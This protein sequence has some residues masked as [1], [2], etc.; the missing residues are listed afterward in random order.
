M[1]VKS[2]AE[3]HAIQY[4]L[5]YIIFKSF[6]SQAEFEEFIVFLLLDIFWV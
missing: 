4:M 6:K 1:H 3:T 2:A 5:L